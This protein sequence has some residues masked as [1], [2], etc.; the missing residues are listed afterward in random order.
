[1]S[2]SAQA[3]APAPAGVAPGAAD[4]TREIALKIYIGLAGQTYAYTDGD[5]TERKRPAP[6]QLALMSFKLAEA[7][8]QADA[9]VNA[10]ALA[11]ERARNTFK[12]EDLD[13][14]SLHQ[15]KS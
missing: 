14:A 10:A 5:G 6:K 13:L 11:V 4:I 2:G 9:E 3:P 1:M 7:F 15:P 12:A 8:Q